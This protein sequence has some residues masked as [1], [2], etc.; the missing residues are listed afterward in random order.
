MLGAAVLEV[1]AQ[2]SGCEEGR[3]LGLQ[4]NLELLQ[5]PQTPAFVT[6]ED[7]CG[8]EQRRDILTTT[9]IT[10]MLFESFFFSCGST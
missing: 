6:R 7:D 4:L 8:D 1:A 2:A 10:L 3:V 5:H 9:S